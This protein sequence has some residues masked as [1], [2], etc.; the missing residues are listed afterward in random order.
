MTCK[1]LAAVRADMA[2]AKLYKAQEALE[3]AALNLVREEV[4]AISLRYP[5]RRVTYSTGNGSR[6][7]EI[8]RRKPIKH[9][10]YFERERFNFQAWGLEY[11]SRKAAAIMPAFFA[12]LERLETDSGMAWLATDV[13]TYQNGR[14]VE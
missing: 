11:T 9:G 12:A 6:G 8:T 2:L 4:A 5:S 10:S 13:F 7:L 1:S 14:E 3:S